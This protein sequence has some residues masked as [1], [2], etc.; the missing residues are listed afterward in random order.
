MYNLPHTDAIA[1]VQIR[2]D[3]DVQSF[4]VN[5][6]DTP[7][8][9]VIY[10][11]FTDKLVF[12]DGNTTF[13]PRYPGRCSYA[14]GT[15]LVSLN[16]RDYHRFIQAGLATRP[17]PN[18]SVYTND[19]A[20]EGEFPLQPILPE[21]PLVAT[22]IIRSPSRFSSAVSY[23]APQLFREE[24]VLLFHFNTFVLLSSLDLSEQV[25]LGRRESRINYY[26]VTEINSN[27]SVSLKG[28]EILTTASDDLAISI[29]LRLT[30]EQ[31]LLMRERGIC[32][33]H[34]SDCKLLVGAK[35]DF[36]KS[37][38]GFNVGRPTVRYG[39]LIPTIKPSESGSACTHKYIK[40]H[41]WFN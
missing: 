19:K 12:T 22:Y 23:T 31:R 35:P 10:N 15:I 41:S 32:T 30:S 18:L 13:T 7:P 1:R 38:S 40:L 3:G 9:R 28:A 2:Y 8:V 36:V 33:G 21:S 11:C 4:T 20:S 14:G 16:V 25:W 17:Y 5:F 29:A 39:S 34:S 37:F 27:Y 6:V 26:G 24:G